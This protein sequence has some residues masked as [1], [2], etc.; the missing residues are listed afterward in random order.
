MTVEEELLQERLFIRQ[1]I[2]SLTASTQDLSRRIEELLER[3]RN[4][5]G[6]PV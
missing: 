5:K 6:V 2:R 3:V 4:P 1:Q